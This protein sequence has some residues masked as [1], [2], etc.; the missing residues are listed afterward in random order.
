MNKITEAQ[1]RKDQQELA[2]DRTKWAMERTLLA[3]ER[4]FSAWVRTGLASVVTGL[5]AAKLLPEANGGPLAATLG[6][7]FVGLGA[8]MFWVAFWSYWKTLRKMR[9]HDVETV[10]AWVVGAMT[11]AL[12]LGAAASL[13]MVF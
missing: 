13:W 4:T 6:V 2:E 1:W 10:P 5:A 9:G 11:A 3:K 7:V 8:A 12:L